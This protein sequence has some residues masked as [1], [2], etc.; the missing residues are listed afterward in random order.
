MLAVGGRLRLDMG[1]P[2]FPPG[3]ASDYGFRHADARRSV[4]APVFRNA[5]P[6]L[7]EAFD[8]ADPSMVT[9]RRNASAVAPQALFLMNHP[10]ALE[11]ARAAARN[12]LAGPCADDSARLDRAYRLALGRM[13]TPAERRLGLEFVAGEAGDR[14]RAWEAVFQALFATAEFRSL[15]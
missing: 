10:F 9:G 11:Q 3:L 7:F 8:F 15:D 12:L 14:E 2:S 4:Y 13:P 1:G 5:L 6:E